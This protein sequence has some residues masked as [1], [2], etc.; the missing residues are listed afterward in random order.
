MGKRWECCSWFS[1]E[2]EWW[3]FVCV[4]V[5]VC[6]CARARAL[7]HVWLQGLYP[8]RLLCPW[9]FPGKNAGM[10]CHFL[11]QGIFPTQG[12]SSC[13]LHWQ[14]GSSLPASSG[15]PWWCVVT[16]KQEGRYRRGDVNQSNVFSRIAS[17]LNW[18]EHV[19]WIVF[20]SEHKF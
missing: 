2:S 19:C 1:Y 14:A 8:T 18:S 10:C 20:Y 11:L 17:G 13:L 15:K 9:N 3:W 6:V 12:P 16:A 5:C 4:C 7:S